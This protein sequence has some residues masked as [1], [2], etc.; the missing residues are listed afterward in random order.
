M[1]AQLLQL[2]LGS[3][4]RLQLV[5]P[6]PGQLAPV[7]LGLDVVAL[8]PAGSTATVQLG[9]NAPVA[10]TVVGSTA[11]ATLVPAAGDV[12]TAVS[13]T[14]VVSGRSVSTTVDV[15]ANI[16]YWFNVSNPNSYTAVGSALN[17]VKNLIS[18]VAS[19]TKVGA[20]LLATDPRTSRLAVQLDGAGAWFFGN[21]AAVLAALGGLDQPFTIII[22]CSGSLATANFVMFGVGLS[23]VIGSVKEFGL[24]TGKWYTQLLGNPAGPARAVLTE[25]VTAGVSAVAMHSADSKT[26]KT[27]VNAGAESSGTV[28]TA[29]ALVPDRYGFGVRPASAPLFPFANYIYEIIICS[30]DKTNAQIAAML[31]RTTRFWRA[32]ALGVQCV[33]D[34]ITTAQN[35]T[36][37]GFPAL[38]A[39]AVAALGGVC[40]PDGPL[41]V[42]QPIPTRHSASSGN[43][44]VDMQT[45]AESAAQGLGTI[46]GGTGSSGYY[47]RVQLVCLFAGTNPTGAGTDAQKA[48]QTS[49][50]YKNLLYSIATRL[51][52]RG[53]DWA[54]SVTTITPEGTFDYPSL[55][56]AYL[57]AIWAQF[58]IDF[59]GGHL[60]YWDAFTTLPF[61]PLYYFD[62]THP[63]DAGYVKLCNTPCTGF[64]QA[65]LPWIMA[66]QPAA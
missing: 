16:V 38:L 20:P 66:R 60:L 55:F 12:G 44:P 24:S 32:L 50:D 27:R 31:D 14:V 37:G 42:G 7:G 34:S 53:P 63:N 9:A 5:A 54:I 13:V 28:A 23:T 48:L 65:V 26:I 11:T 1:S 25:P 10:M 8:V 2:L 45:R 15:E 56:N 19:T 61:D 47:S 22:A 62:I 3:R 17:T 36:N 46:G 51:A 30:V 29:G 35:A 64:F 59:P 4:S 49:L 33:G 21:E 43:T 41:Q 6:Q 40:D 58:E 57:P 39:L 18:G 52:Q